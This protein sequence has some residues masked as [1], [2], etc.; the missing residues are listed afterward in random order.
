MQYSGDYKGS[1]QDEISL[2]DPNRIAL[3]SLY[4]QGEKVLKY[5]ENSGDLME[6]KTREEAYKVLNEMGVF[7]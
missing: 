2:Q 4:N 5:D 7:K 1:K 3:D 6:I